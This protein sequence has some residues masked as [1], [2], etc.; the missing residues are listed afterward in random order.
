MKLNAVHS[1]FRFACIGNMSTSDRPCTPRQSLMPLTT[2]LSRPQDVVKERDNTRA[3]PAVTVTMRRSQL[4]EPP[5][6][7]HV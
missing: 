6:L 2:S 5:A 1:G 7:L 4:S 3:P